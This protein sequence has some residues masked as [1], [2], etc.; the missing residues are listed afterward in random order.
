MKGCSN[1]SFLTNLHSFIIK[2]GYLHSFY[3]ASKFTAF[4][5]FDELPQPTS[6][7]WTSILRCCNRDRRFRHTLCLFSIM[8]FY[9]KPHPLAI[10]LA[11][12]A[13]VGLNS[14]KFGKMIH[15]FVK[16]DDIIDSNLFVGSGLID[17]YS[18]FGV[19]TDAVR[20]F[21]G[22]PQPDVVL[23][24]M[25]VTGYE[26]NGCP[27]EALAF[28][29]RM[30]NVAGV[31]PDQVT[32]ISVL[33]ACAK[34]LYLKDGSSVHGMLIKMGLGNRLSL[35]NALLNLYAK[36]GSLDDAASLFRIM[37]EKDVISWGA[38]ISCY[39]H[40]GAAKEAVDLFNRMIFEK[41]EPNEVTVISALQACEAS[42]NLEEGK[43]IH[44]LAIQKGLELDILV[45]TALI[46]MYMNCSSPDEAVELFYRMPE[47][48]EVVWSALLSGCVQNGKAHKSVATFRNMLSGGVQPD[49]NVIV[50][51]LT[52]YSE[53]GIIQQ[54]LC[55]HGYVIRAGY[56][57]NSFVEA[58]LIESYSK[59]G[60]LDNAI[61][62]FDKTTRKDVVIWSSMI[63][64][65]GVHGQGR[66]ALDLF[67]LMVNNSLV[68]P[69]NVTFLSVLSACSHAGLVEEG[70]CLF[71][72]MVNEHQLTPDSNHYA[73]VVD[74]L[75]RTGE[76]EKAM[77]I[78]NL[79][80]KVEPH[81]W[82][83]FLGACTI[84]QKTVL[85]EVAT[86]NLLQLDFEHAGYYI[87]MSNIYAADGKWDNVA[88]IRNLVKQKKMKKVS[89]VSIIEA[90]S[91]V[92][93]FVA[94][95]RSHPM[96]TNI[97]MLLKKLELN[98]GA[99][100]YVPDAGVSVHHT[101]DFASS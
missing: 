101:E 3:A 57:N 17:L 98:M 83:A 43:K 78:I 42:C 73:I 67:Y 75:G 45:S 35:V 4:D 69:N 90:N 97:Y 13:C 96:T 14:L 56:E 44:Q 7:T 95:D 84:H 41:V 86:R 36:T 65:Y 47:K 5:M 85:G 58:S 37:E 77:E 62:I 70:I 53:L 24:T 8:G 99:E 30:V 34:L 71:N 12:K 19:M 93:S 52:A 20:V 89:A 55:L 38:M 31:S 61:K 10:L 81:V 46:D 25:I 26:H 63:A 40:N 66:E 27:Q 29:A 33:S 50:K 76:L 91:E 82:G 80:P 88:E 48:D 60:S 2:T 22:Y 79:M 23:W 51:I 16:K 92:H 64:G 18:K 39:A 74:L 68:K 9:Q 59:C 6:I 87:L 100:G 21:E 54:T 94:G 32:L 49:G 28:F 15:G 72:A 1:P 11:L